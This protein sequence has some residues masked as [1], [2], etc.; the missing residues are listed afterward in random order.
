MHATVAEDPRSITVYLRADDERPFIHKAFDQTLDDADRHA[1]ARLLDDRDP[2]RAE[3]LRL[4][5]TLYRRATDDPAVLAR[6]IELSRKIGF[7]FVHE[8]LRDVILNCGLE[9]ARKADKRVRF[10][11][12]CPKRWQTLLPTDSESVRHCQHCDERVH[13]C[14][15][16]A[17]AEAHAFAGR[18]IAIPR[19]LTDGG[20]QREVLGRP[21]PLRD[22][23]DRL[24]SYGPGAPA[25]ACALV[26]IYSRDD[27]QLG[28]SYVL[29]SVGATVGR[30]LDNTIVLRSDFVSRHHARLE[31]REDGWW[32][33]DSGSTHGTQ[34]DDER[35]QEARLLDGARV[36]MGDTIFRFGSGRA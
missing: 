12:T 15:T 2:D 7:D 16:V 29:N 1:Y 18:C 11:F 27:D 19:Q 21:T 35:V 28:R 17:E 34:I 33:I 32:V 24:F 26:V 4:E 22:W 5:V 8:F 9:E 25:D 20:V 13:S 36:R 14:S 23:A 6:F 30:E 31:K 10:T 3:W